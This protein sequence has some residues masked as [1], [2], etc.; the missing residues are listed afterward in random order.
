ML[1]TGVVRVYF[2]GGVTELV[3]GFVESGRGRIGVRAGVLRYRRRSSLSR[4][5]GQGRQDPNPMQSEKRQLYRRIA[6]KRPAYLLR[7]P[8]V[9]RRPNRNGA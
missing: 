7:P 9:L 8:V 2:L 3:P 5:R 1:F 6:E 4:V